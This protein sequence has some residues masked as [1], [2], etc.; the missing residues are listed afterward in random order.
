MESL[1]EAAGKLVND[2]YTEETQKA[3]KASIAQ[4]EAVV[5]D[6]NRE[7]SDISDAYAGLIHA[8]MGLQMRG[9]KAALSAMIAK[10][11][12]VLANQ[13]AYVSETL[14]GLADIL[15]DAKAV[16]A[17]VNAIQSTIDEALK[18]LTWKVADARLLGDIDGDHAVTTNDSAALLQYTAEK[19]ELSSDALGSADV[20]RDGR[21]DTS[22]V[23]LILQYAAE[24]ISAF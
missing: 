6:Q 14:N 7:Q 11:E 15:G 8:I 19:T 5:A 1:I 20:N 21:T 13:D 17:D 2:K 4:A 12:E 18:T 23:A 24:K 3:L 10:A 22:D 16:E 9:N